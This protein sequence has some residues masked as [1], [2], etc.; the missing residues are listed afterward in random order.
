MSLTA[1]AAETLRMLAERHT[2][3]GAHVAI[4]LCVNL[5]LCVFARGTWPHTVLFNAPP[6]PQ[7][8]AE[9]VFCIWL[10]TCVCVCVPFASCVC[11][12][13]MLLAVLSC[14]L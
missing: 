7:C 6:R 11:L 5:D 10:F 9:N 3:S 12:N 2:N 13:A 4:V 1:A 14:G 8:N